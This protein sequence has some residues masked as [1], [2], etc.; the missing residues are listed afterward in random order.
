MGS[1]NLESRLRDILSAMLDSVTFAICCR[2]ARG[3]TVVSGIMCFIDSVLVSK[4]V[5]RLCVFI[6]FVI[7][8]MIID[9]IFGW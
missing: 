9:L 2:R 6:L 8:K 3:E 7:L 1:N 4:I 5:V